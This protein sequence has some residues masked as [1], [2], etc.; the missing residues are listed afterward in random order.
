MGNEE[1]HPGHLGHQKR[2][3]SLQGTWQ[4]PL[5][6]AFLLLGKEVNNTSP[7]LVGY[8]PVEGNL[9]EDRVCS[10][11]RGAMNGHSFMTW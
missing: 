7:L 1:L 11:E 8:G 10:R 3:V 4:L 9:T 6:P 2:H 5:G